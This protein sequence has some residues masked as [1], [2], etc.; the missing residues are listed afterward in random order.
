MAAALP[1]RA[2]DRPVV[3]LGAF[4]YPPFYDEE[5]GKIRGIAVELVD[6]VFGRMGMRTHLTMFPLKRA[7][8]YAREGQIDGIMILIKT[9]ER[10]AYL[11]FTDPV[12]T[13][14]GLIWSRADREGG[15]V[16]FHDLEE[17]R[18]YKMGATLGYSYGQDLDRLMETMWVE[19]VA[20]DYLNYKKLLAAVST[21]FPEMRL[22]P[23]GCLNGTG[24][25]RGNSSIQTSLLCRGFFIWGSAKNPGWP[26]ICPKSTRSW[27]RSR[28]KGCWIGP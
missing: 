23:G 16:H 5:G 7:L 18:P 12:M 2:Q 4:N 19:R 11:L 27:L 21:F 24:N 9:A 25:C 17:L 13:V 10:S 14:R 15:P 6:E 8:E 26:P 1:V 20:S 28:R 22:W 3:N